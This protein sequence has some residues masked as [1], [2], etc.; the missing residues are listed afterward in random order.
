MQ[1]C[2]EYPLTNTDIT[3]GYFSFDDITEDSLLGAALYTNPSQQGILNDNAQPPLARD[4]A[5]FKNH[6]FF[7]DVESVYRFVFT[8]IATAGTGLVVNDTITIS[9]GTTT[10][11]YT[12]K[13]SENVGS[14]HFA[15]DTA[16]ASPSI[17]IDNTIRSFIN[18]VNR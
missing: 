16:S 6:L 10:E 17:R 5:E 1:L 18:I 15:V 13:A 8:L 3:N 11:V 12:A 7:A 4:I 2:Y 9:D 14:K